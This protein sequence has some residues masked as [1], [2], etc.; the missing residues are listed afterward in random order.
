MKIGLLR[1]VPLLSARVFGLEAD[2]GT[3]EEG[4]PARLVDA[5]DWLEVS[6]HMRRE[7]CCD[8]AER[9]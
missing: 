2:L 6:R 5:F 9:D 8:M 4:K 1:T 3:L 7:G